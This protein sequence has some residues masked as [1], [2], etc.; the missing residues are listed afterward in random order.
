MNNISSSIKNGSNSQQDNGDVFGEVVIHHENRQKFGV[1]PTPT[2]RKLL[3]QKNRWKSG[4]FEAP[5]LQSRPL[6][7]TSIEEPPLTREK[8]KTA[9]RSTTT[10]IAPHKEMRRPV[11]YP[12]SPT[13]MSRKSLSSIQSFAAE[14]RSPGAVQRRKRV[15]FTPDVHRSP[16]AIQRKKFVMNN[17]VDSTSHIDTRKKKV[18]DQ[19]RREKQR[20]QPMRQKKQLGRP[21]R[22]NEDATSN[23]EPT[24]KVAAKFSSHRWD[25]NCNFCSDDDYNHFYNRDGGNDSHN[26]DCFHE[27]FPAPTSSSHRSKVKKER[28]PSER[29]MRILMEHHHDELPSWLRRRI[30]AKMR[31]SA[32]FS[33][34]I[35]AES[36]TTSA[37]A[38]SSRRKK[39]L[40]TDTCK[41]VGAMHSSTSVL[42]IQP[43]PF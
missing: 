39:A 17:Q 22:P 3:L 41:S 10:N 31:R 14:H 15:T 9:R 29:A 12:N 27:S 16:G 6:A 38:S 7:K 11:H 25:C 24:N 35:Q 33:P 30:E 43:L 2:K 23:T 13:A 26:N 20:K 5:E 18:S 1:S 42:P 4:T 28:E 8:S 21:T 37:S 19:R 40:K 36:S 34:E 32:C